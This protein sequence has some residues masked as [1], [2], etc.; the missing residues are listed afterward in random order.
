MLRSR[1]GKMT[2]VAS[3]WIHRTFSES[4]YCNVLLLLLSF[5]L[6]FIRPSIQFARSF[7]Q[8][9]SPCPAETLRLFYFLCVLFTFIHTIDT[10]LCHR[11]AVTLVTV[12]LNQFLSIFLTVWFSC[13]AGLSE[14][15]WIETLYQRVYVLCSVLHFQPNRMTHGK[16]SFHNFHTSVVKTKAIKLNMNE[17][18][19]IL[20]WSECIATFCH[21]NIL[22]HSFTHLITSASRFRC[23]FEI[24]STMAQTITNFEMPWHEAKMFN[25]IKFS[26]EIHSTSTY[27]SWAKYRRKECRIKKI[28]NL[29]MQKIGWAE[30]RAQDRMKAR[31]WRWKLLHFWKSVFP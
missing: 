9:P 8:L 1:G 18:E 14:T 28:Q 21:T 3:M 20:C 25:Q 29:E 24:N 19:S 27:G 26:G 4:F 31:E 2:V 30:W 5:F 10:I 6:S 11:C 17:Y 13:L 12:T 22:M 16:N 7:I 15:I 23:L